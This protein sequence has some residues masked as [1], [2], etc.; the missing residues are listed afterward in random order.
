[1]QSGGCFFTV[2]GSKKKFGIKE[3]IKKMAVTFLRQLG[4]L[5]LQNDLLH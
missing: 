2:K 3:F 1:M 5:L 4:S